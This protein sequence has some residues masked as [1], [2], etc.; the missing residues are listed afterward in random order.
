MLYSK[1]LPEKMCLLVSGE[2]TRVLM[3]LGDLRLK[4]KYKINCVALH[5]FLEFLFGKN[6]YYEKY[7]IGFSFF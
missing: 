3:I 6:R 1:R 7:G 2:S 5:V 4:N